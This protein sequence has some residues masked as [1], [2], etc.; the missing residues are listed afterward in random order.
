MYCISKYPTALNDLDLNKVNFKEYSGFSDHSIGTSAAI[1]ALSN[2]ARIIEKHFTLDKN[3]YGPDHNLSAN[4][5]DLASIVKYR[6]DL[7]K[8]M[9]EYNNFFY[10]KKIYI[11]LLFH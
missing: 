2:G 1:Y 3:M 5:E 11:I 9:D 7:K 4:P 6:D 10:I 8:L